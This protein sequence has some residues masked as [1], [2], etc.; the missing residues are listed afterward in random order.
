MFITENANFF[1]NHYRLLQHRLL[2][3]RVFQSSRLVQSNQLPLI[4]VCS[5]VKRRLVGW[6][7]QLEKMEWWQ[8]LG[9]PVN[10]G[11]NQHQVLGNLL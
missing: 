7:S 5:R 4:N 2:K 8:V 10:Q 3:N 6:P 11:F 1:I 9:V